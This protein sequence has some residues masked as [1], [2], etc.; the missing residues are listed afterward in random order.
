MSFH[1]QPDPEHTFCAI[2]GLAEFNDVLGR[3]SDVRKH[4]LLSVLAIIYWGKKSLAPF[5]SSW[6]QK[7]QNKPI[8][9]DSA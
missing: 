6:L 8:V 7:V 5:V 1:F 9:V 4:L 2:K 3:L